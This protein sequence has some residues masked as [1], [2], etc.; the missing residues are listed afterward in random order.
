MDRPACEFPGTLVRVLVGLWLGLLLTPCNRTQVAPRRNT[1]TQ[2]QKPEAAGS[3]VPTAEAEV[4]SCPPYDL[5]PTQSLIGKL[6]V[7]LEAGRTG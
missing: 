3:D 2:L 6:I 4:G 7:T 1:G 5:P